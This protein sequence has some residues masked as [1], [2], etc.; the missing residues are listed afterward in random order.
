M[1]L[2]VVP[3]RHLLCHSQI[4]LGLDT[5]FYTLL[6]SHQQPWLVE[7]HLQRSDLETL[8]LLSA[9]YPSLV[10]LPIIR[11]L[12]LGVFARSNSAQQ[13]F[14]SLAFVF[15]LLRSHSA[16]GKYPRLGNF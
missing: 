12:P 14:F 4:S 7:G 11:A 15:V 2:S 16:I 10:F 8:L 9:L 1:Y 5:A 3:E 13:A 6:T